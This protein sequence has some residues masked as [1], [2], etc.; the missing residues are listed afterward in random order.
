MDEFS[1]ASC[2]TL[3]GLMMNFNLNPVWRYTEREREKWVFREEENGGG[4]RG[5]RF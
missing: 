4:R 1:S 5:C 3:D 2:K